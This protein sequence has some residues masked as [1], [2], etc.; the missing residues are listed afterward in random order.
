MNSESMPKEL[1]VFIGLLGEIDMIKNQIAMFDKNTHIG[2]SH[3]DVS[4]ILGNAECFNILKLVET[5][6]ANICEVN[7][8]LLNAAALVADQ[9]GFK[10]TA[11]DD[12]KPE[13]AEENFAD[14]NKEDSEDSEDKEDSKENETINNMLQYFR[15]RF[16]GN[17]RD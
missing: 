2:L 13:S 4:A 11:A 1:D 17:G 9:Y 7:A 14:E 12:E 3:S 8:S 5:M 16:E 6:N 15:E 10:K